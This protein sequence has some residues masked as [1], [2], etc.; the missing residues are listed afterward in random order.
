MGTIELNKKVTEL[1]ELEQLEK[2]LQEEMNAIR[3][4]LKKELQ[5]RGSEEVR[6]GVFTIRYKP[7]EQKR[8]DSKAFKADHLELYNQYSRVNTSMRFT[9]Q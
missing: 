4:E 2:D 9:V 3:E 5:R 1:K 8:F 6:T 7:V